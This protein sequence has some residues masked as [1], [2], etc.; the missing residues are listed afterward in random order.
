MK[1]IKLLI[2]VLV[3]VIGLSTAF[4]KAKTSNIFYYTFDGYLYHL[5]G[6][7][8]NANH[9]ETDNTSPFCMYRVEV[10]GDQGMPM[11]PFSEATM[12]EDY[13]ITS[14]HAGKIYEP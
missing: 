9:C 1:R 2:A 7:S 14:L 10:P 8:Y 5:V 13:D 3:A 6:S 4:T 12:P 11:N